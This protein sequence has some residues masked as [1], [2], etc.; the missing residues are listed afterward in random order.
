MRVLCE[1]LVIH[2][3]VKRCS[4]LH[5]LSHCELLYSICHKLVQFLLTSAEATIPQVRF[6]LPGGMMKPI[7]L[8]IL[9]L[10]STL[11]GK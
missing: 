6:K 2:D 1:Q 4:N 5:C 9:V 10:E 8:E 3:E 11:E 7:H